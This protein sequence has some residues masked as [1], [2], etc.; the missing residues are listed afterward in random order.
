MLVDRI[1]AR[2]VGACETFRPTDKTRL[3]VLRAIR[4]P[5]C[6]APKTLSANVAC[7][8]M[9][10]TVRNC[11]TDITPLCEARQSKAKRGVASTQRTSVKVHQ[12]ES[13][14]GWRM[15]PE[16]VEGHSHGVKWTQER[17]PNESLQVPTCWKRPKNQLWDRMHCPETFDQMW[18]SK[19]ECNF[20]LG[21]PFVRGCAPWNQFSFK[22]QRCK[23]KPPST[24]RKTPSPLLHKTKTPTTPTQ[25]TTISTQ[26]KNKTHQQKK[27]LLHQMKTVISTQKKSKPPL[28]QQPKTTSA[29]KK[30]HHF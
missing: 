19:K 30:N 25:K 4:N 18:K 21:K 7:K 12:D 14:H 17:Q 16:T 9:P 6:D 28:L 27:T 26:E 2:L 1:E 15:E 13:F 20:R 3:N 22:W 23:K 29:T 24:P 11:V 10:D 5:G 8:V